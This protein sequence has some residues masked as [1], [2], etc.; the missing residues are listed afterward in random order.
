MRKC[1]RATAILV[2]S[3]GCV[4]GGGA[5]QAVIVTPGL[6]RVSAI[7]QMEIPVV[8]VQQNDT[9]V[10]T[11]GPLSAGVVQSKNALTHDVDG[12]AV[13]S[14]ATAGIVYMSYIRS[15]SATFGTGINFGG[16]SR[17][18]YEFHVD[19]PTTVVI[20]YDMLGTSDV[21]TVGFN[22]I[23]VNPWYA[24]QGFRVTVNG[25]SNYVNWTVDAGFRPWSNDPMPYAGTY[26]YNIPAGNGY[27]EFSLAASSSGNQGQGTRRMV[28]DLAFQ[29]GPAV[30][31]PS[32]FALAALGCAGAG[33]F[34]WRRRGMRDRLALRR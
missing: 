7:S 2:V 16:E 30:P 6:S 33:G 19:Q 23:Q 11:V 9:Q 15:D 25:I 26:L 21:T 13:F 14:N 12:A 27:L 22:G 1:M 8:T 18:R 28:G 24:M 29:I 17:F 10:G 5:A 20:N 31:E 4:F 34:V 3:C 32:S